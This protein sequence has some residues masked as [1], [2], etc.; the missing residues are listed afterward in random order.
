MIISSAFLGIIIYSQVF[1][2]E[3]L[4]LKG[5]FTKLDFGG[6]T[7]NPDGKSGSII[8]KRS[9]LPVP[10]NFKLNVKGSLTITTFVSTLEEKVKVPT[11]PD[12]I[13]WFI[14]LRNIL[15][16]ESY[17]IRTNYFFLSSGKK[18]IIEKIIK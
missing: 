4:S 1:T 13:Q 9:K 5:S 16:Q 7:S 10:D 12:V 2:P 14:F 17:R 18:R 15:N 6:K 11:A 3:I 8:S